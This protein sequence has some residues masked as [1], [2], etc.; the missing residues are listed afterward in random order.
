MIWNWPMILNMAAVALLL[1]H[2][3]MYA[4]KYKNYILRIWVTSLVI[5]IY[6][7]LTVLNT[8]E[9][10]VFLL[11]LNVFIIVTQILQLRLNIIMLA[12]CKRKQ[13]E[14]KTKRMK[15]NIIV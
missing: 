12:R 1:S 11:I 14:E 7:I 8:I 3:F 13:K 5:V 4:E 6:I 10:N 15:D 2:M 9:N